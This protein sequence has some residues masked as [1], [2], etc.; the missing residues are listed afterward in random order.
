MGRRCAWCETVLR[1]H[2]GAYSP[3]SRA[4]CRGCCEELA[5]ALAGSG[6]R[7]AAEDARSA[8]RAPIAASAR[9]PG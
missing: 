4:I 2:G 8:P 6:L 7:F 9:A 5:L 1:A 3:A